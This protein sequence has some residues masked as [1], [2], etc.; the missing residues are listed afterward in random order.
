MCTIHICLWE[1]GCH[2]DVGTTA[3]RVARQPFLTAVMDSSLLKPSY[4]DLLEIS[5]RAAS[6]KRRKGESIVVVRESKPKERM[7]EREEGG[8]G[9]GGGGGGREGKEGGRDGGGEGGW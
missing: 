5:F 2:G 8:R 4:G 1:A 6:D 7:E 9:D 3:H